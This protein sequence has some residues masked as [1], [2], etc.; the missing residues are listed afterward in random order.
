MVGVA[1]LGEALVVGRRPPEEA[2]GAG[3]FVE[4]AVVLEEAD[5]DAGEDPGDGGLRDRVFPPRLVREGR[6]PRGAGLVVLGFQVCAGGGVLVGAGAEVVLEADEE[7]SEVGE[8]AG[9]V[10]HGGHHCR[11]DPSRRR[12]GIDGWLGGVIDVRPPTWRVPQAR[13]ATHG[14]SGEYHR[15]CDV[16]GVM[17]IREQVQQALEGLTDVQLVAVAHVVEALRSAASPARRMGRDIYGPLYRQFAAE[18]SALAE[19]GLGDFS[20]GLAAEDC[21]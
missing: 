18:D 6:P 8:E 17:T 11:R 5:E 19:E 20:R 7:L 4:E 16:S 21:A 3:G 12:R 9:R 13:A 14:R 1:V 10:D 15:I 2:R